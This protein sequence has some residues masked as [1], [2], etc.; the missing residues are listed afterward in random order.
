MFAFFIALMIQA[1]I[2]REILSKMKMEKI[3]SITLYPEEREACHP[4]TNKIMRIFEDV[5]AYKLNYVDATV[6]EFTDDL[7]ETQQQI[8]KLME[9]PVKIFW[10]G[11]QMRIKSEKVFFEC[12]ESKI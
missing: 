2:E 6:E 7:T 5:S 9:M 3:P 1:L 4:T 12:A 8:I 10:S 11:Y